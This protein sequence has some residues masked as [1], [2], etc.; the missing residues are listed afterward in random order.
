MPPTVKGPLVGPLTAPAELLPSPQAIVA[1]YSPA[2]AL[3]SGSVKVAT[4]PLK[5]APSVALELCPLA[6]MARSVV[7]ATQCLRALADCL[8]P[9]VASVKLAMMVSSPAP[10]VSVY[11][12]LTLPVASVR[13]VAGRHSG[14]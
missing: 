7:V 4:V 1:E 12:K 8:V 14:R 11:V 13:H 9:V 3:A 2:V 5:L 6:E 10:F